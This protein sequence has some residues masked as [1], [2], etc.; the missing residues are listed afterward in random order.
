MLSNNAEYKKQTGL[1]FQG[2]IEIDKRKKKVERNLKLL[3]PIS[4]NYG[5]YARA[6]DDLQKVNVGNG[7]SNEHVQAYRCLR[8]FYKELVKIE[9][10]FAVEPA[11]RE[12]DFREI[13]A[14]FEGQ[15]TVFNEKQ[16]TYMKSSSKV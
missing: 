5:K 10:F 8:L 9:N 2:L 11:F 14:Q 15:R 4:D 3:R 12:D 1:L 16:R 7:L 13:M 6:F